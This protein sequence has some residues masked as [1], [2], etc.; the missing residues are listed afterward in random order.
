MNSYFW[1][2]SKRRISRL[3]PFVW[4]K[5]IKQKTDSSYHG[6]RT[7]RDKIAFTARL[8]IQPQSQIFRYG[9]SIFCQPHWSNFP[10]IFDLCLHWVSVVRVWKIWR[11][12]KVC[13]MLHTAQF[14]K[15]N[16]LC[17]IKK[18]WILEYTIGKFY[19]KGSG[20]GWT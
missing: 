1:S 8:K 2:L 16:C 12:Y 5:Y 19:V 15:D 3:V 9:R 4:A 17:F 11:L 13:E 10:D 7:P 20:Q 6:L 18:N 14:F